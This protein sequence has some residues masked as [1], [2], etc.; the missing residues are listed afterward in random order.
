[1]SLHFFQRQRSDSF[2]FLSMPDA[3]LFKLLSTPE[4]RSLNIFQRHFLSTLGSRYLKFIS[5][6]DFRCLQIFYNARAQM[7][8]NFFQSQISNVF[9]AF[10][11]ESLDVFEM[12][13]V[14]VNMSLD[15]V[16]CKNS[17]VFK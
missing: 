2:K 4:F 17:D 9:K 7:H 13:N 8:L 15:L 1:M 6:T 16:Q 3:D 14:S 10:Q 12:F 11:R 5:T